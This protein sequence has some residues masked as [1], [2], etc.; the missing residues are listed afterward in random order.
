MAT[1]VEIQPPEATMV[2]ANQVVPGQIV[3]VPGGEFRKVVSVDPILDPNHPQLWANEVIAKV[4]DGG[5]TRLVI[6][7]GRVELAA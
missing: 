4:E 2:P 6:L 1:V 5:R 7:K 3:K